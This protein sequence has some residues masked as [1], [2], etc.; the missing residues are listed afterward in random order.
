MGGSDQI[1]HVDVFAILRDDKGRLLLGLRSAQVYAGGTWNLVCG[2]AD[3]GEDVV[4]A[5]LREAREE[6]GLRLVPDDLRPAAVVH[7]FV[8]GGRARVG[9]AFAAGYDPNRHG[10]IRNN[11][12]EKCDELGWFAPDALPSPMLPYSS[13]ILEASQSSL[14]FSVVGWSPQ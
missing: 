4:T 5:V 12:P 3:E 8:P 13:A 2:K 9:F 10:P 6:I 14:R 7:Y 11:E 1:A